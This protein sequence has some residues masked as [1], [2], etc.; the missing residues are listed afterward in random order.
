M[1]IDENGKECYKC[2]GCGRD[3]AKNATWLQE[4]LN[5]CTL[6]NLNETSNS[7]KKQKY[8]LDNLKQEKQIELES[9]LAHAFFT[10]GIAFNTIENLEF[11]AFLSKACPSFRILLCQT[12]LSLF[13]NKNMLI[14]KWLFEIFLRMHIIIA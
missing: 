1:Q 3:W 7:N 14:C 4:H 11:C 12:L 10:S 8:I 6:Q 13:L 9:L 5:T 2:K